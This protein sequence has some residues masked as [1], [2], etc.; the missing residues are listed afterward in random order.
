MVWVSECK[1]CGCTT[2]D[3]PMCYACAYDLVTGKTRQQAKQAR[4]KERM[5]AA[6]DAVEKALRPTYEQLEERVRQLE[7]EKRK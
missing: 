6:R 1:V 7:A 4:D 3:K 2:L 5:T